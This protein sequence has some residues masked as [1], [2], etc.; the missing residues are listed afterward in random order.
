MATYLEEAVLAPLR[1]TVG[2]AE[3]R[4]DKVYAEYAELTDDEPMAK[5]SATEEHP[6]RQDALDFLQ[7]FGT[8]TTAEAKKDTGLQA[9]RG[10]ALQ[11]IGD[12]VTKVQGD[13]CPAFPHIH[14]HRLA[15]ELALR[16][17]RP[18]AVN[19]RNTVLCG[20]AAIL[21]ASFK[22]DPGRTLRFVLDLVRLGKGTL[23][24]YTLEPYGCVK[25][26]PPPTRFEMAQVD[27]V[28][29]ASLRYHFE[30]LAALVG[31]TL[32]QGAADPLRQLTKPGLLYSTLQNMGYT[33]L[34]DRTF[35]RETF[36]RNA[37]VASAVTRA[38]M[39]GQTETS[40]G[41]ANL[42][43]A[44]D[45]LRKGRLIFL[46]GYGELTTRSPVRDPQGTPYPD[47]HGKPVKK[48]DSIGFPELHWTLVRK[49]A[50]HGDKVQLRHYSWG[51][52][53]EASFPKA[54]FFNVYQG[55]VMADPA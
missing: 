32:G 36:T 23:R 29:L 12:F 33:R 2:S 14:P 40:R 19:Q 38:W 8:A 31:M 9:L 46:W 20:A 28:M 54:D 1:S 10:Q 45:D 55:H 16:A 3:G 25:D 43:L 50:L 15:I 26:E 42:Q 52:A 18:R 53:R 30:P 48:N 39:H 24:G 34:A 41:E 27:W 6:S 21:S 44:I 37:Q 35:G 49:L 7:A 47:I 22:T 5:W 11:D 51:D 4:V 13:Q 17:R